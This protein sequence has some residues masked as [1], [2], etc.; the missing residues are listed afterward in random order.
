MSPHLQRVAEPGSTEALAV[1]F[2]LDAELLE[3]WNVVK[4]GFSRYWGH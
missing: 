1:G 2:N 4:T 3:D